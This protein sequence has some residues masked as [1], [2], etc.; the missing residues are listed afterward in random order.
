MA[1]L[2]IRV[3]GDPI[4]KEKSLLISQ[5]NKRVKDLAANMAETMFKAPGVGL[6]APQVGVA[7]Q[8]IVVRVGENKYTALVNPKIVSA[9]KETVVEEEGCLSVPDVKVPVERHLSVK[10]EALDLKGE[11]VVIEA[12]ELLARVFQHEIDHLQGLTIVD[13]TTSTERH[14]VF[15]SILQLN[16]A[17]G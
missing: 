15:E 9:S 11:T 3:W 8:I 6:A 13:R 10:L 4:L 14:R 2:P 17:T 12:N 1:V 16:N 7:K 5:L